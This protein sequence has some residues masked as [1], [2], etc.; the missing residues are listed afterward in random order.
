MSK[1]DSEIAALLFENDSVNLPGFGCFSAMYSPADIHPA[2]HLFK[3]PF[4]Q[5][6]FS[7]EENPRDISLLRKIVDSQNTTEQNA[8]QQIKLYVE[9]I[10]S[11]LATSGN[12]V[13]EGIGKL[14]LDIEKNLLFTADD[15]TNYLL[16]SYGLDHF[17]SQ[18]ILRKE[19]IL[20]SVGDAKTQPEKKK[21]KKVWRV[22]LAVV[23]VLLI[24][25]ALFFV[26]TLIP[27]VSAKYEHWGVYD[28]LRKLSGD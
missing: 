13:V 1:M 3:P 17:I 10:K 11:S 24:L 20:P 19:N 8:A 9:E 14:Y 12:F 26:S 21:M 28:F 4:K 5:I 27:A 25:I 15:S 18:P 16:S 6:V 23:L 22:L 7:I 2:Q